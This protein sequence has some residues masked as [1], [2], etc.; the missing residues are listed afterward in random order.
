MAKKEWKPGMRFIHQGHGAELIK[1]AAEI[2]KRNNSRFWLDYGTMLGKTRDGRFI[3][4]DRDVDWGVDYREWN[5]KVV[6]DLC[7]NGFRIRKPEFRIKDKRVLKFV[8][9][10]K[11]NAVIS[12]KL[13]YRYKYGA[14]KTKKYVFPLVKS[15]FYDTEIYTPGDVDGYLSY[16]YG[17]NWKIHNPKYTNSNE[18]VNNTKRF[19]VPFK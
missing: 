2:F 6:D 12:L 3:P 15:T 9:K 4:H 5:P 18:H 14:G 19:R 11:Y 16:M 8:G 7:N 10:A 1:R 17:E 13:G